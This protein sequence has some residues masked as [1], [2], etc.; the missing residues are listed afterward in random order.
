MVERAKE[1]NLKL[2]SDR[3]DFC[4]DFVR[5]YCDITETRLTAMQLERAFEGL[6]TATETTSSSIWLELIIII[7]LVLIAYLQLN[8]DRY[9]YGM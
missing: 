6:A 3:L 4:K 8:L 9:R 7:G 1:N 5:A 2:Q